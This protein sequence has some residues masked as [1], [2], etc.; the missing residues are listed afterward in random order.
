MGMSSCDVHYRHAGAGG[1]SF[2]LVADSAECLL[3]IDYLPV[4]GF[5]SISADVASERSRFTQNRQVSNRR[6]CPP[7]R[8]LDERIALIA[9]AE[10]ALSNAGTK[11][12]VNAQSRLPHLEFSSVRGK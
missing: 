4:L 12:L 10:Y 2:S 5:L 6:I 7:R 9:S 1:V 11:H 8:S 3:S